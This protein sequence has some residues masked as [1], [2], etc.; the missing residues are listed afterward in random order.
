VVD[1]AAVTAMEGGSADVGRL[2]S[3]VEQLVRLLPPKSTEAPSHHRADPRAALLALILEQRARAGIPAEGISEIAALRAENE[4]LRRAA[5]LAVQLAD[6]VPTEPDVV[7]PSERAECDPGMR[8][9]PDDPPRTPTV[10]E[11]KA[12]PVDDGAVD[13]RAGF[14]N[15][16]EPWRQFSTDVEGNPL[17]AR[18]RRYWG[19]V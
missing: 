15:V 10:I 5:G 12:E 18:G 13:I 1:H 14:G 3:A 8:P 7:P 9:G 4:Q 6:V 2:V 17:T 16:D 19:P 11:G